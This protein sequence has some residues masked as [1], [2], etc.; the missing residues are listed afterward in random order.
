MYK[1]TSTRF[2]A[3]IFAAVSML[4]A[5]PLYADDTAVKTE[6][7]VVTP[8]CWFICPPDQSADE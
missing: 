2:I 7:P 4:A 1:N 8:D 5:L 6:P 3:A